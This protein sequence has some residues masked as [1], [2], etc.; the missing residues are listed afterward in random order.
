MNILIVS[1]NLI[2]KIVALLIPLVVIEGLLKD[3]IKTKNDRLIIL[4]VV[5]IFGIF[6]NK[7]SIVLQ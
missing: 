3:G 5:I 4:L 2:M 1:V 7:A 6:F